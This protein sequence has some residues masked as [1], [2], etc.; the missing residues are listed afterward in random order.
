MAN[1][2]DKQRVFI[3]EY[4]K[5]FNAT[6]AARLA[7][8]KGNGNTL[9]NIGWENLRKL[10]IGNEISKRLQESAMSA[11]EVL[12]RLGEQ[13]RGEHA[14]YISGDGTINLPKLLEDNKGHLIKGVK[15]TKYG[16]QIEFYDSQSAL[17]LLAKH[18]GLLVSKVESTNMEIDLSLLTDNQLK[19]LAAGE[20]IVDVLAD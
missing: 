16:Q 12:M 13:A 7:G 3:N 9:A 20:S 6:E 15:D 4:L 14:K 18:H 1:L 11:N 8:Y 5:C 10:D 2:T 17:A 19:R